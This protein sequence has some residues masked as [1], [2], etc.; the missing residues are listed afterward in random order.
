[1]R[2]RAEISL[3]NMRKHLANAADLEARGAIGLADAHG[4]A[5]AMELSNAILED[6]LDSDAVGICPEAA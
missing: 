6:S 2:T 3:A 4:R 1:M 5:A